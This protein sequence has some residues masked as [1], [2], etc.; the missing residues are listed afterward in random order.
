[1]SDL[2]YLFVNCLIISVV[3]F[4]GG[5]QALFYQTMVL[6]RSLLSSQDLSA[7]LAFA[8]ATPGPAVFGVATFVGFRVGGVPGALVGTFGIFVMP[9]LLAMIAAR[10]INHWLDSPHAHLFVKGVGL[11]AAGV[12]AATA[13]SVMQAQALQHWHLLVTL[14]TFVAMLRWRRLNPLVVLAIGALLGLL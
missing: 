9:C 4:G 7:V 5:S 12:V 1:V 13:I 10:Y 8:Y 2:L 11:A 3:S 6:Q 14:A